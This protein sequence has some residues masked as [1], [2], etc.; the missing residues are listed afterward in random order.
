MAALLASVLL[1]FFVI[2][3]ALHSRATP[4]FLSRKVAHFGAGIVIAALPL[5][6]ESLLWPAILAGGFLVML[7]ATHRTELWHG[8]ARPGRLS[9]LAFAF[10]VFVS[11]MVAWNLDP[12]LAVLPGLFMAFGDGVTGV[13]RYIAY[14]REVKGWWGTLACLNVCALLALLVV[15]YDI[16]FVGAV[17]FTVA[18]KYCGDVGLIKVDDNLAA[19]LAALAVM[20]PLYYFIGG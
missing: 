14:R 7:A 3:N 17:V 1:M 18:E 12:W 4:F 13:V 19:P 15:P 20:A 8:F 2:S 10:S 9:E 11:I 16:G 6:F 5:R